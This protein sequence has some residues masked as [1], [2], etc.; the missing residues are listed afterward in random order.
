MLTVAQTGRPS[1]SC[2]HLGKALADPL[3]H[4]HRLVA[5]GIDQHGGKFLAAEP[6]DQIGPAHRLARG[7]GENF[8]HAVAERVAEAVIDR[9]EVIEI[10]QQH[11]GRPRIGDMALRQQRRHPAGTSGG[12]RCR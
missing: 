10:D 9:L 3:G 8:Q 1:T 5:A 7:I 11:R 4:R 6:A 2:A 12:W